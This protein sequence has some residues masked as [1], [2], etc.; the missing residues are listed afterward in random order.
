MNTA[1]TPPTTIE[2]DTRGQVCPSTLLITLQQLNTHKD[3]IRQ[4]QTTLRV[5]TDNRHSTVTIP[6]A[7]KNM[8]YEVIVTKEKSYYVILIGRHLAGDQQ[9]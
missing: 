6:G 3:A 5:K 2:I 1:D 8:G 9:P 4:G 7:V